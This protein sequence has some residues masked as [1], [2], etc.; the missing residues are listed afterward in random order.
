V[1]GDARRADDRLV[2]VVLLVIAIL[3]SMLRS[4]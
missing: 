4:S 2:S 3:L 1:S